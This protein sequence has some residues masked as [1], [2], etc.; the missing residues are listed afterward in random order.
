[1]L[2]KQQF[3]F[4]ITQHPGPL[5][6]FLGNQRCME[7]ELFKKGLVGVEQPST[8]INNFDLF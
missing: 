1:M 7:F 3:W 6:K 2:L 5:L 4:I 8:V